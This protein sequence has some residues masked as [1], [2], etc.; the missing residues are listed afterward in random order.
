MANAASFDEATV[1]RQGLPGFIFN[2]DTKF[3]VIWDQFLD[4]DH[5]LFLE[6]EELVQK[7]LLAHA[8]FLF[9]AL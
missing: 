8:V 4:L 2:V 6:S 9:E 3:W 7:K 1:V 5:S